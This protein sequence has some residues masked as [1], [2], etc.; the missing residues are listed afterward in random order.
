MTKEFFELMSNNYTSFLKLHKTS[1]LLGI[2][3][4]LF[5]FAFAYDLVRDDFPKLLT[6][7]VALFFLHYKL[8][9]FQSWNLKFLLVIG[10]LFRFVFIFAEPNLSQDF[11]RFI[12][13]G[14][15]IWAGYNPYIHIPND[16]MQQP[17]FAIPNQA[18]LYNGMGSLSAKHFSNYPPINQILF[19][20]AVFFGGGSILGSIVA[21]RTLILCTDIGILFF[22]QKLLQ[23][24]NL[25]KHAAFWYFLN[26]LVII[27]L[28]G[29]LHFEGVMLF[30]FIWSMYLI[31][32]GKWILAS[33]IYAASIMVKLVPI[34]FLPLFLRYF[35]IKRS[36][37]F[38]TFVGLVC[39]LLFL[40]FH[41]VAFV[42][43]YAETIG[44]WF[45]NFEFN[46]GIYNGLK[47]IA[48]GLFDAK[49]WELIKVYG[50]WV[51]RIT[52]LG[53]LLIALLRKNETLDQVM[54]SMLM[55]L[56][57]YY[58]LSTTVHPW[59]L[60]FLIALACFTKYRFA[61]L[62]SLLVILSYYAYSKADYSENLWL[63]AIEYLM[64]FAYLIYEIV[65]K[66]RKKLDFFKKYMPF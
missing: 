23:Q 56:T 31:S 54:L 30:F 66:D 37:L 35:G 47:Q 24:F 53:T 17:D 7:F 6:L 59:Y 42:N 41:D 48:V 18:E 57:G 39:I 51:V 11:Y 13:D 22:G 27:E 62:W 43:N 29:N 10:I 2:G 25:P 52:I 55:V 3:S 60:V 38:Y 32:K 64:V 21:M 20:I 34:L 12:W 36:A 14:E 58:L 65:G 28:T 16:L 15:L 45:S 63:L 26:P 4:L 33:P 40:P 46:A 1:I 61:I 49:P 9:Q 5:Y 50:S 19:S 44:L 8:V